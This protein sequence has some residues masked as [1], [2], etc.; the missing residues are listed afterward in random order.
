MIKKSI[1]YSYLFITSVFA[2]EWTLKEPLLLRVQKDTIQTLYYHFGDEFNGASLDLNKWHDN[3]PWG[4]VNPRY[5][6]PHHQ[7]W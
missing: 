7:K 4:G 2:Q 6:M 1:L 3:Y 5:N